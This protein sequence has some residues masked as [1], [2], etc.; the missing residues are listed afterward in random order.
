MKILVSGGTGFIGSALVSKLKA[1]KDSV[2]VITRD[3]ANAA[4]V[5]GQDVETV[6]PNVDPK[7]LLGGAEV[8]VSL[9]GE[10][11]F[12]KR[13][14]AAQKARIRSSRVEGTKHLVTAIQVLPPEA[15]PKVFIS[16]SAV[17]YYGPRGD[18]GLGEAAAPGQDFLADVCRDWEKAALDA[19]ALGVR[20]AVIR[21]GIVLGPGGGALAQM[22]PI[23]K[24]G[25]GGP[26]GSGSQYMSWIHRD[27]HVGMILHLIATAGLRGPVNGT[28]PNPRT[29]KDFAKALG[30]ALHRP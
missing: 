23:F 12:G 18:Q 16:G 11:I 3:A 15:R 19:E 17:G 25:G 26:I 5:L 21:T 4:F 1:R 28:A 10:P 13:W 7:T 30:K 29:N 6:P 27:D 20:V 8:V 14:T 22:M 24:L 9:L 2:R